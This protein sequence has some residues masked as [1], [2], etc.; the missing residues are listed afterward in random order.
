MEDATLTL[1]DTVSKHLDSIGKF[2]RILFMDFSS[3]FNTIQPYLLLQR[4]LD[5]QVN[6]T[7][8][9]WIRAFLCDRPQRVCVRVDHLSVRTGGGSFSE[10]TVL[11]DGSVMSKELVLN[12]GAPQ[13]CVLSQVLPRVVFCHRC[14]PW[15]CFV[16]GAPQGCVLSQVLPRGVF[17]HKCSPGVCFV[18]SAPQGCVLSQVLPR[19]VFCHKCSPGVCFVTGAPQECV[20]SQVLPRG[21]FFTSAPQG[22]VLSQVLPRGVFCHRC[23]PGVCF[24]TSAPQGCVLSQVLQL[25]KTTAR[26][27]H[28]SKLSNLL[29]LKG[30]NTLFAFNRSNNCLVL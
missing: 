14:S 21:C 13:G 26:G 27:G 11:P 8:V 12:T 1:L 18:T 30:Y 19:G 7:L 2:F 17:C 4:L 23:S 20:L 22:C 29:C 16:T 25:T 28:N 6:P 5:L 3:A 24:V 10:C 9:L 15:V